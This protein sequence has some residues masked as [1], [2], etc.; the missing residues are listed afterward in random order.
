MTKAELIKALENVPDN[1][2]IFVDMYS[3]DEEI[4]MVQ[5]G[6]ITTVVFKDGRLKAED[7]VFLISCEF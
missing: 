3:C 2:D 6:E 4:S 5:T 7:K 1:M